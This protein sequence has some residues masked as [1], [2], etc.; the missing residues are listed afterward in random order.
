MP[1][2]PTLARTAGVTRPWLAQQTG[3]SRSAVDRWF[4]GSAEAPAPVVEWL[5]RRISDPPPVLDAYVPV[6]PRRGA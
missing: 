4:D 1:D 6:P 5:E 3:R 2:F